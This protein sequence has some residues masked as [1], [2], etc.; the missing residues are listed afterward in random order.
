MPHLVNE[1]KALLAIGFISL[2]ILIL[3][4]VKLFAAPVLVSEKGLGLLLLAMVLLAGGFVL[5]AKGIRR[6]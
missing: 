5:A 4:R 3:T 1:K 2:A 6:V